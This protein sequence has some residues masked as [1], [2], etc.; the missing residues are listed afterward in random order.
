[1][2]K[3][4]AT[5]L[6]LTL[7]LAA[8]SAPA[9]AD[10]LDFNQQAVV[11]TPSTRDAEVVP[12]VEVVTP[13]DVKLNITW[14]APN[15][16]FE[17][18]DNGTAENPDDD[19]YGL[20]LGTGVTSVDVLFT[21]TN[22]SVKG[23]GTDAFNGKVKVS[24]TAAF[25]TAGGNNNID[26]EMLPASGGQKEISNVVGDIADQPGNVDKTNFK[27]QYKNNDAAATKFDKAPDVQQ[28]QGALTAKVTF[29]VTPQKDAAQPAV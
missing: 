8:T 15:L 24:A 7:T 26:I 22:T 19:F 4:L 12:K 2:K 25:K 10:V 5:V 6:A 3:L 9:A 17:K 18:K 20:K 27:L 13:G 21:L 14:E 29:T 11:D 16:V 23:E 1:M 28:T